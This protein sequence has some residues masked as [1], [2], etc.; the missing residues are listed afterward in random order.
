MTSLW[1]LT[2]YLEQAAVF[3]PVACQLL[4]LLAGMGLLPSLL[5]APGLA[6]RGDWQLQEQLK[7]GGIVSALL[8]SRQEVSTK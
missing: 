8:G 5:P 6:C 3:W 4:D 2:V 1:Q 7:Y